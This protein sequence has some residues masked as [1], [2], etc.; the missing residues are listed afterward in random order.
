MKSLFKK[1]VVALL[2]YEA[3]L[4]IAKYKPFVVVVTGS[5]GKTSTKDAIYTVLSKTT[6]VST[7]DVERVRRSEKSFNSEFGVPLTILG[8][9]NAWNDPVAWL[10]NILHGLEL[11][12]FR[13]EY[14]E[15]LILEVGADHPGDIKRVATWLS[16]D[17]AVVTKIG[18]VPVH[19]EFFPSRQSL[20][21]EKLS[22][23]RAVKRG[24]LVL[25]ADDADI[26]S[27]FHSP[28]EGVQVMTYGVNTAGTVTASDIHPTYDTTDIIRPTGILYKLNHAG[29]SI[30][31]RLDRVLGVQHVYPTLAATAVG[32]A[33][34]L[35][36][37][38]I[39]DTFRDHI[40]PPGRMNIIAGLRGSTI[41]DD[42]YNASP[43]A[44]A[45]ALAV[46]KSIR[47][48]KVGEVPVETKLPSVRKIAVLGDMMELG[49]FSQEEHVKVGRLAAEALKGEKP[50]GAKRAR[51]SGILVTVGQRARLIHDTAIS[52]GLNASHVVWYENSTIAAGAVAELVKKGDIVLVKGSQSPR[53]ER[54]VKAIMADPSQAGKLLVRQDEEWLAR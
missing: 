4:V 23:A 24:T 33:H 27:A 25:P 52:A 29:N 40:A 42:T 46:L 50:A 43:D 45:E 3:R 13:S 28:V 54:I 44:V 47:A 41:I 34:G 1:I 14:P 22:L 10:G 53:M 36:I 20:V 30:P 17:V 2:T 32:L 19:I 6:P 37:T 18:T 9:P 51:P 48:E 8:C 5:I 39:I 7:G 35:S 15:V 12:M 38:T 16:P 21:D 26:L 49:K 11:I 31:V